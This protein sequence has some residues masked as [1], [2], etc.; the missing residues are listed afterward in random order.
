MLVTYIESF[1][2]I[3][4]NAKCFARTYLPSSSQ[5]TLEVGV[6]AMSVLEI[7]K[8]RPRGG[9]KWAAVPDKVTAEL[10]A[11]SAASRGGSGS[12]SMCLGQDFL[13]QVRKPP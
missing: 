5:Q 10:A 8:L 6:I 2:F 12:V 7:G 4:H 9:Q 11:L 1:L 3:K 13:T